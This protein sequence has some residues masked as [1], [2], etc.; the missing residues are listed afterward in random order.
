[1]IQTMNPRTIDALL[2]I[3][4]DTDIVSRLRIEAAEQLLGFEAPDDAIIRARDFLIEVFENKE[5]SITDRMEALKIARKSE[6][7]KVTPKIIRLEVKDRSE[8]ERREE[9]RQYEKAQ[10]KMAIWRATGNVPTQT[11]HPGWSDLLMSEDYLPPPG[12]EWPPWS[13]KAR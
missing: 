13:R 6:A 7:A 10:L 9:W 4:N 5:E 11:S 1:M 2:E 12:D 8:R 3:M